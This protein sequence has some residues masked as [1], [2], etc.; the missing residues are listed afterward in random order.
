MDTEMTRA[1]EQVFRK[2]SEGLELRWLT[3]EGVSLD[4]AYAPGS[5]L[6]QSHCRPAV[7]P[8]LEDNSF[9]YTPGI[10][11][12]NSGQLT[13]HEDVFYGIFPNGRVPDLEFLKEARPNKPTPQNDPLWGI[14]NTPNLSSIL[15]V[16]D[17]MRPKRVLMIGTGVGADVALIAQAMPAGGE[18]I[19]VDPGPGTETVF[20]VNTMNKTYQG[21]GRENLGRFVREATEKGLINS[22]TTASVQLVQQDSVVWFETQDELSSSG[23]EKPQFDLIVIDGN[24]GYRASEVDVYNAIRYLASGGAMCIDDWN[25]PANSSNVMYAGLTL[26]YE[27]GWH[28]Y[29]LEHFQSS[30]LGG[31]NVAWVINEPWARRYQLTPQQAD[32]VRRARQKL[33]A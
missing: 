30:V 15:T 7:E 22:P 18:L 31:A 28:L 29:N 27:Y 25:K 20:G 1:R 2:I 23:T 4:E 12:P 5:D 17:H 9:L 8:R 21:Y 3:A 6:S 24:H 33:D 16:V 10:A 26:A 32:V 14:I 13:I 11:T 19:G